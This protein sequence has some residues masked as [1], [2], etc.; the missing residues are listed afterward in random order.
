MFDGSSSVL[1]VISESGWNRFK[2]SKNVCV[3]LTVRLIRLVYPR[4]KDH[5]FFSPNKF[6]S[7]WV[8]TGVI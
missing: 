4:S 7:N 6:H 3:P 8:R 5:H 1:F 2:G